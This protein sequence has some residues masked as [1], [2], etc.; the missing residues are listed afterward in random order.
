MRL[1]NQS[2]LFCENSITS[3]TSG[4][5]TV[6]MPHYSINE[7]RIDE[8]GT[9]H[10]RILMESIIGI[11]DLTAFISTDTSL[12][13]FLQTAQYASPTMG[14]NHVSNSLSFIYL[15]EDLHFLTL[16]IKHPA[17]ACQQRRS[18]FTETSYINIVHS[19][20]NVVFR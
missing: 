4:R 13:V 5:T 14:F 2:I 15:S 6:S 8:L 11:C 17:A 1:Q 20:S 7:L 10:K 3:F 16:P 12:M 19:K 9:K 18:H